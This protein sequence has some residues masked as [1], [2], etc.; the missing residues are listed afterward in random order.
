VRTNATASV[1]SGGSVNAVAVHR[2]IVIAHEGL[3]I[4][5]GEGLC[6]VGV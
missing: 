4:D 5:P 6:R 2:Y 3:V 1:L